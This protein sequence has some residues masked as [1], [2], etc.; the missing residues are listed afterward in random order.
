MVYHNPGHYPSYCLLFKP[1]TSEN[2]FCLRL[3]VEPTA[4]DTTVGT[5]IWLRF[6]RVWTWSSSGEYLL[7]FYTM[8]ASLPMLVA[9]FMLMSYIAFV[10]LWFRLDFFSCRS[11]FTWVLLFWFRHQ[12]F[13][14]IYGFLGLKLRIRKQRLALSTGTKSVG[15][16]WRWRQNTVWIIYFVW[17][18]SVVAP[19]SHKFCFFG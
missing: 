18:S 8:L 3:Q 14:I 7:A 9:T 4:L 2:A 16:A 13:L 15:F 12:C 19:T 5:S 1:D 11:Y 17:I 10:F 6:L